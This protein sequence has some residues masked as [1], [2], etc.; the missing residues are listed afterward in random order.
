MGLRAPLR[1]SKAVRRGRCE[2]IGTSCGG[3]VIFRLGS[4]GTTA[5]GGGSR[6]PELYRGAGVWPGSRRARNAALRG[7][8]RDRV[9]LVPSFCSDGSRPTKEVRSGGA[10]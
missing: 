6:R 3:P 2:A 7:G 9:S 4:D 8:F 5:R 10:V 1:R